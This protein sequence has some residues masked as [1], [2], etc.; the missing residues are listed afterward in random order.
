MET[1]NFTQTRKHY[2]YENDSFRINGS[3]GFTEHQIIELS[4][5]IYSKDED[6]EYVGH[7]DLR[8][9]GNDVRFDIRNAPY[10]YFGALATTMDALIAKLK[11]ELN[12]TSEN[13]EP[14]VEE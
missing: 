10:A 14:L 6:S 11:T 4:A 2:E 8:A 7:L 12:I 5:E 3:T 9:D 13:S 1:L